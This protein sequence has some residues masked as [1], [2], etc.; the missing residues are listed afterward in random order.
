MA[1]LWGNIE[2]DEPVGL[3]G[4]LQRGIGNPMT[5]AGLGL[6]TG[7]GWDAARQGMA[8][9]SGFEQMRQSEARKRQ[10]ESLLG[11][12]NAPQD[13]LRIAQMQGPEGGADTLAKYLDP[14]READLAYKKALTEKAQRE[15]AGGLNKYGKTGAVFQGPDGNFYT[16]QFAEDGSRKIEPVQY[17]GQNG[18][19]PVPLTP[20]RGVMEVGDTLVDKST[21]LPVRN[22]GE[23]L[24]EGKFQETLGKERAE[25]AA[26]L[27]AV[28]A[29]TQRALDTVEAIRNHPGKKWGVGVTGVLPGIP[30]TEQRGFVTLVDQAKGQAF[31]EA[32]NSLRGGG[33]IT[34]AEG[35]KATE[36]LARLDR[37]Q[38]PQD[39]DAALKDYEDVIRNGLAA[40]R[41]KAGAPTAP[42]SGGFSIRRLD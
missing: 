2:D 18:S 4:G 35:R 16:M 27:P 23:N 41:K 12:I 22:V 42:S 19:A 28:E 11:Q 9:G 10:F 1:G 30:G 32:F 6:L 29:A 39:F 5:L 14:A 15:A 26:T 8:M 21:G 37:A 31:L 17:P 38:T 7:G 13:I 40:V 3:L 36:A 24:A 34:E 20:A 33:Q 25:V